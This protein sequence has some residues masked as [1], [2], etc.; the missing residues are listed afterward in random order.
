MQRLTGFKFQRH[1]Y[2]SLMLRRVILNLIKENHGL[3]E[4]DVIAE[5]M[6]ST[7]FHEGTEFLSDSNLNNLK[8]HYMTFYWKVRKD[9]LD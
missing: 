9:F 7:A 1:N 6:I 4:D 5:H 2:Q 3:N 8:R